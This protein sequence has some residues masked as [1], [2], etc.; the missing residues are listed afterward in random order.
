MGDQVEI[1]GLDELLKKLTVAADGLVEA[2]AASVY[3]Q[4][5]ALIDVANRSG[6]VPVASGRLR[7]SAYVTLPELEG[8]EVAV[9]IGYGAP[10]AEE[11]HERNV[12][13][14]GR[15]GTPHWLLRAMGI[16]ANAMQMRMQESLIRYLITGTKVGELRAAGM[17]TSP[18]S[19]VSSRAVSRNIGR[20]RREGKIQLVRSRRRRAR[21]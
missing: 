17:P 4:G 9:E 12:A 21:R 15:R 19:S 7:D 11:V 13:R 5:L 1:K 20:L 16:A 2:A 10:Y 14:G 18:G 3:S 8:G 6:M